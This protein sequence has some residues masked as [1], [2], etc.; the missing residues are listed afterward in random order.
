MR[1][2]SVKAGPAG[3]VGDRLEGPLARDVDL[4]LG[5]DRAHRGAILFAARAADR[6]RI[7]N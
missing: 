1:K 6:H 2:W 3:E 4:D 7:E 5:A